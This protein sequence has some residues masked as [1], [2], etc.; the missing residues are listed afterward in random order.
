MHTNYSKQ[1]GI[2]IRKSLTSSVSVEMELPGGRSLEEVFGS[3][4]AGPLLL[5]MAKAAF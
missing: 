5:V 4:G 1:F 2:I 3:L